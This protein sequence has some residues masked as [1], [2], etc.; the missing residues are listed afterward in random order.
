VTV[1]E[2]AS[3]SEGECGECF[4][5]RIVSVVILPRSS[6]GIIDSAALLLRKSTMYCEGEIT[7]ST[8]VS[9]DRSTEWWGSLLYLLCGCS[10]VSSVAI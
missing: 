8:G 4:H 6:W 3:L 2:S 9:F 5:G 7:G 1:S 10:L